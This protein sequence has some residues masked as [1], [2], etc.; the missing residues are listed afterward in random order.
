MASHLLSSVDRSKVMLLCP[1]GT[2]RLAWSD[3]LRRAVIRTLKTH[4]MSQHMPTDR[5]S[6]MMETGGTRGMNSKIRKNPPRAQATPTQHQPR[7][8]RPVYGHSH[9]PLQVPQDPERSALGARRAAL[10][11]RTSLAT[12]HRERLSFS[13][14]APMEL[15]M[16][17]R[18]STSRPPDHRAERFDL[19][20]TN[21]PK[22]ARQR[23]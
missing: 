14:V 13:L 11:G 3:C 5:H 4:G 20:P 9:P 15:P 22:A 16:K 2:T 10:C 6:L 1:N 8:L 18:C 23:R 19:R 21:A 17:I 7:Q 12:Q